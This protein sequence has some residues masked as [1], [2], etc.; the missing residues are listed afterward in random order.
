MQIS[1]NIEIALTPKVKIKT[2]DRYWWWMVYGK[3]F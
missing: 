3:Q 1:Q 2:Q